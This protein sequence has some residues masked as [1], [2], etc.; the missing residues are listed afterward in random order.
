M[1]YS[2]AKIY[3]VVNDV[4]DD[5]YIGATCQSLSKRMAEHRISM[6][7]KRDKHIKLY[8]KMNEIG[9][10]HFKILLIAETPCDNVEQL[11]AIEGEYI[12][13]L[14]T[15]NSQVAGRTSSDY[16]KEFKE[17]YYPTKK[18]YRE[19]NRDILNEKNREY[20]NTKKE[21]INIKHKKRYDEIT[22]SKMT[23]E[24]CRTIH[25]KK[26]KP[27]HLRSKKHQEALNNLNNRNNVSLQSDNLR[28]AGE[29]TEREEVQAEQL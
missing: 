29:T 16:C 21:E 11:R 18:I 6:R 15:L 13:E 9:V 20:Y 14:G 10:E 23:C 26:N 24:V 1:D 27:L 25:N 4:N 8:Q 19:N 12:K 22:S 28:E 5:I 7:S 17:R 2:K 3:K